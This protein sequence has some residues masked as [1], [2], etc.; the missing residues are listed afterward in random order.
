M[1]YVKYLLKLQG[2]SMR[3]KPSLLKAAALT[4]SL[5]M[6]P[7]CGNV[8]A[9]PINASG[10]TPI[11]QQQEKKV[12][13]KIT[14]N[15]G[16]SLIGVA[17]VVKGTG[18]GTITDLEG[19]YSLPHVPENAVLV[20]S[21]IGM[22]SQEISVKG[23]K[24][25]DVVLHDDAVGIDEVV[26]VGYV[27]RKKGE[28]TGSVSTLNTDDLV[29][30]SNTNL[31]KSLAGKVP[32]LIVADRGGYP[33]DE[34][35]TMLIRGKSTLGNNSPLVVIDGVPSS[36]LSALA[37]SDIASLTVLKD[38]AAAI[39]GA[40]AA[41]G[42]IVV[43]TKRGKAGKATVNF[44]SMYKLSSFTREPDLMD[45]WQ[46][47]TWQNEVAD[48]YGT[49]RQ[50][51]DEDIANYKA[52]NDLMNY[53][54]TDWRDLTMRS[55]SPETRNTLSVSGG[56]DKV[57]Y[58]V[59]A[60]MVDQKG[61][62]ESDALSYK[63]YQV[64]SNLDVK[65]ND[66]V[67]FGLDLYAKK[68]KSKSPGVAKGNIY[69]SINVNS[70][71]WIGQYSNGLPAYGGENGTNPLVMSSYDSGFDQKVNDE[72]NVNFTY[73]FNFNKVIPG[74]RFK[75][76]TSYN[77]K[78]KEEKNFYDTWNV[79]SYNQQ[80]DEYMKKTGFNFNSGN[81]LSL[82]EYH[83]RQTELMNSWQLHY[84]NNFLEDHTIRAFVAM[85]MTDG[86]SNYFQAYKRDL[87]SAAHPDLFAGSDEG[88]KSTGASSEWGRLN[89]FG[90]LSYDYQHKYL[91]DLT[92]RYDG[93]SNFAEG[94]RFG[95]FPG[96]SA[97]WVISD[98]DFMDSTASWLDQ[99]KLR[100]SW[101]RM[102]NDRVP[103]FQYM[104]KYQYGSSS[105]SATPLYYI[106]GEEGTKYSAF[107]N[108][109]VPNPIITW[110]KADMSNIGL[111]FVMLKNRLSAD[112]NYFYQKRSDIL[113]T[114]SASVADY[115]ALQLPQENLGKVNNYG[116]EAQVDWT[117]KSGDLT[118]A[119]G[120][121]FTN[122][123]NEVKYMDEAANVPD[124]MKKEG[125]PMDSYVIYPCLMI[126]WKWMRRQLN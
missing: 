65:L 2:S 48:I 89:Y 122:A 126:K 23:K 9:F 5:S 49:N 50:Y 34:S 36:D 8:W 94:H 107:Y 21:Y 19:N 102:G 78:N 95:A 120:F 25:I 45:S 110:E 3:N 40:R 86:N 53:P 98:E 118:Y 100:A 14:D 11:A 119:V 72:V 71:T 64:R 12:T 59:S 113:I 87:V 69:K 106:L 17:V 124:A 15:N 33:G 85:E 22:K 125:H 47:A 123:K 31:V 92:F 76:L 16:E 10:K 27:T 56:S 62:F 115:T 104:T 73:E 96:V 97:G 57:H 20:F 109:N 7:L 61:L 29:K 18:Q 103:S 26:V 80:T 117:D 38:G 101:A 58:F 108:T 30:T 28:L 6:F 93:S 77:I 88:Q 24:A 105:K 99:L 114:R 4:L 60:D 35:T 46:Y 90:S 84:T 55:S 111:N 68:G 81:F 43:T 83:S 32:G 79:Y 91:L 1:K 70:P 82:Q 54:N 121:N 51:T 42:V 37:P 66:V 116:F 112:L 52:G 39:Y 13:G 44:S 63:N 41:N 67:K 75:G 74:L